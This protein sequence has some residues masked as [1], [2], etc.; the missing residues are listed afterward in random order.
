MKASAKANCVSGP[1]SV[2]GEVDVS[3]EED[4]NLVTSL[5][6]F[7]GFIAILTSIQVTW[8][9]PSDPSNPHSWSLRRRLLLAA[10][11]SFVVALPP[12]SSTMLAPASS[13]LFT[14][15]NITSTTRLQL[16]FS[17]YNLGYGLGPLLLASFSELHGRLPILHLCT[18]SFLIF[19]TAAG[20]AQ[21]TV[22]LASLRFFS[23]F[24]GS[25]TMSIGS[26]ILGDSFALHE[27][28]TAAAVYGLAPMLGPIIGPVAGG[29]MA[30]YLSWRWM[31]WVLSLVGIPLQ[32]MALFFLR[33]T[34][35]PTILWKK[36]T[37]LARET[38]NQHL[39]T[40]HD[41]DDRRSAWIRRSMRPL[42]LLATQP[43]V[44]ALG[45]YI[46]FLTGVCYTIMYTFSNLWREE[47][48]QSIAVSSLNYISLGVG[49]V[50][51]VLGC[52]YLNN[53]VCCPIQQLRH[54]IDACIPQLL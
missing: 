41:R 19:N 11:L 32:V 42:E 7:V 34:H 53:R 48:G 8:S 1:I 54:R 15:L 29:F 31:C 10:L 14:E 20:F 26:G 27:F 38:G 47:Y 46:A 23:A 12:I 21:T 51:G 18:A 4:P 17:I 25:T 3:K 33:E 16:V 50:I 40:V 9:K 28:G 45:F 2:P 6:Q 43:L 5:F 44:Q 52:S 36:K 13:I 24:A 39:Y 22:Q 30:Q 49:Y 37:V 35:A